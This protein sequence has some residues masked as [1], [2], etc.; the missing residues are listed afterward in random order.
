MGKTVLLLMD[1][2]N[3]IVGRIDSAKTEPYLALAASTLE[4]ARK[5]GIPIIY[6]V[7][8][9]RP[10]CPE[11]S[12][13]SKAFAPLVQMNDAFSPEKDAV[14]IHSSIAPIEGKD[15]IVTKKRASAFTGSDLE[16]V[17]RG[18]GADRIVMGGISTSMVVL[19]T[20][21]QAADL[22]YQVTIL[23][24]LCLDGDEELHNVLIQKVFPR[25]ADIAKAKEWAESL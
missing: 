23:E 19:S 20:M 14:K 5:K 21:R 18:L 2:Q 15:I 3:G 13:Q 6:C 4:A 12:S 11:I 10:G 25:T 24:D 8:N 1:L 22:D 16:V 7:I 17:L 9:F